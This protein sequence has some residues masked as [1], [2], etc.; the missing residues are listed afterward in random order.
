MKHIKYTFLIITS[1]MFM[2]AGNL[3]ANIAEEEYLAPYV[4]M[5]VEPD[6]SHVEYLAPY[7]FMDVEPDYSNVEYL[8]PYVF[9]D[10]ESDYSDIEHLEP[11]VFEGG[12]PTVVT[13][14]IGTPRG[15]AAPTGSAAPAGSSNPNG[16][17]PNGILGKP[18]NALKTIICFSSQSF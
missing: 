12:T 2:F 4:F 18:L 16:S 3:F 14:T 13:T 9:M 5:D 11:Y 8:A 10:V 6:Y 15:S 1:S 17:N 7:V